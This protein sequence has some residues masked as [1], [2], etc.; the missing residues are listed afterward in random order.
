M[1][2][3]FNDTLFI[4]AALPLMLWLHRRLGLRDSDARPEW[5]EIGLHLAVWSV[6]TEAVAPL[7]FAAPPAIRGTWWPTPAGRSSRDWSGTAHEF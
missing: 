3:Y 2:G 4:P 6:A 1:H 5:P 7:L